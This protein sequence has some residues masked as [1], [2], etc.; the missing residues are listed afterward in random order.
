MTKKLAKPTVICKIPEPP[1]TPKKTKLRIDLIHGDCIDI[2]PNISTNMVD[3]I[4][5][6]LPYGT[7]RC[8]WDT[9]IPLDK[10]WEQYNRIARTQTPIV[11]HASQPFT[12][13]LIS[14]NPKQFKYCCY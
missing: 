13:T 7:T 11:L 3:T 2:L 8:K 12:S 14:S 10:L 9:V 1:G 4:I 5:C 6:D